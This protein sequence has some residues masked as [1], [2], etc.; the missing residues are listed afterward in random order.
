MTAKQHPTDTLPGAPPEEGKTAPVI[1]FDGVCNLCNGTVNFV[2][3]RDPQ[4]RFRFAALQ[5]KAGQELLTRY[6]L[7]GDYLGSIVLVEEGEAHTQSTSMLKI[8]GGL[9]APWSWLAAFLFVPAPL[10]DGVYKLIARNR[11]NWFGKLETC[12]VPTE[13]V[14]ARFVE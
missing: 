4:A 11:Y 8:L 2:I 13:D 1:L 7:P 5:S 9:D 14:I 12:R 6:G 3:D 10:R